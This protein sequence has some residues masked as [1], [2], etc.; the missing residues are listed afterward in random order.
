[1]QRL[2]RL[3]LV[4]A[5]SRS[6]ST[7]LKCFNELSWQSFHRQFVGKRQVASTDRLSGH[8]LAATAIATPGRVLTRRNVF[9]G[10]TTVRL[11][12]SSY[13]KAERSFN[14][15]A[16]GAPYQSADQVSGP[17]FQRKQS[18]RLL[19]ISHRPRVAADWRFPLKNMRV[20]I[21]ASLRAPS[22]CVWEKHPPI[23]EKGGPGRL[24]F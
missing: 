12:R 8:S 5:Y 14:L 23:L 16:L 18:C 20:L 19:Q 6:P 15:A 24:V 21:R 17:L 3:I 10:G 4:K 2:R 1:L 13:M 9:G 11:G 7:H 22:F